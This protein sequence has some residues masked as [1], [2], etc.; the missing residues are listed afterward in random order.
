LAKALL[1]F[2]VPLDEDE[3]ADFV[4]GGPIRIGRPPNLINIIGRPHGVVFEE[5]YPLRETITFE[6]LEIDFIDR[7]HFIKN[8]LATGRL[9][10]LADIENIGG[11]VPG[12]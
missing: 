6:L 2:Q 7:E 9:Q 4:N 5:C 8:K 10:D 11:E 1:A 3:I 12:K